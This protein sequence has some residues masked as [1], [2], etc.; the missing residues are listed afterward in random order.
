MASI[1]QVDTIQDASG[2]NSVGLETISEGSAKAW[3]RYNTSA[4]ILNSYNVST[5]TDL[6]TGT[7]QINFENAL[8]N[9]NYVFDGSFDNA[10]GTG[11]AVADIVQRGNTYSGTFDASHAQIYTKETGGAVDPSGDMWVIFWGA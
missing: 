2:G 3:V 4:A 8:S 9:A 1:L 5:I 6:A 10:Y 7:W 11:T